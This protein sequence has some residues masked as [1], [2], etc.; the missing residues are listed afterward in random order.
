[1]STPRW[2]R[3][4]T[5]CEDEASQIL[6]R[7]ARAPVSDRCGHGHRSERLPCCLSSR[8]GL[9]NFLY[10]RLARVAQCLQKVGQVYL[11]RTCFY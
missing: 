9:A 1:M 11:L 6:I 5:K 8:L 4:V 7:V 3:I 2:R 10:L